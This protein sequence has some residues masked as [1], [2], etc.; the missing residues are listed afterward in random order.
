MNAICGLRWSSL[1]QAELT[2]LNNEGAIA[3]QFIGQHLIDMLSSLPS[4]ELTYWLRQGRANNAEID[5]VIALDR[6]IVPIEV[7]ACATGSLRSLHQFMSEKNLP[8]AV[9]FDARIPSSQQIQTTMMKDGE[10]TRVDYRHI[11]A[12]VSGGKTFGTGFDV[13]I[14]HI[15]VFITDECL[16][17]FAITSVS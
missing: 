3:E 7:K 17:W 8:V 2:N 14:C 10:S 1:E 11:V 15:L 9:R 5:Y 12:T 4:R 6:K 16:V 13:E